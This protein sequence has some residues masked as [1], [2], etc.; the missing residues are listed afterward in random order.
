[1]VP[2]EGSLPAPKIKGHIITKVG[3]FG[4]TWKKHIINTTNDG[5]STMTCLGKLLD[6][7]LMQLCIV[8]GIQLGVVKTVYNTAKR[9]RIDDDDGK[10]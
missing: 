4:L 7:K 5:C 1:M 2:G 9:R 3:S 8:H 6:G 10:F